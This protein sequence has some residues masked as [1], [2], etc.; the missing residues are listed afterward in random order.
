MK[1]NRE[2]KRTKLV[3]IKGLISG[4]CEKHL[5]EE[6]QEY[7]HNLA[8]ALVRKRRIDILRGKSPQWVASIIYAIARVNFLF[9]KNQEFHITATA[10]KRKAVS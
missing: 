2:A 3:E 6:Y 8:E 1:D 9:D 7:C 4:F 10:G 5:N